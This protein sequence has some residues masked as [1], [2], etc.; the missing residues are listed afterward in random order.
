MLRLD[1]AAAAAAVGA[2]QPGLQRRGPD[3]LGACHIQLAS[4]SC[5][6]LLA[7][8]L[9]QLRGAHRVCPPLVAPSGSVVCF[10]GEI[11]GG[12]DIEPGANDGE[13]LLE[14]LEQAPSAGGW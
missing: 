1:A 3:H 5:S 4:G 12:L 9:L 10:N 8:S 14:A 2:F 13:Q 6:L 11:F 7:A